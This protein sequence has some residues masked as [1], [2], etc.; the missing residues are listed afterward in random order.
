[1]PSINQFDGLQRAD[2]VI[3]LGTG[4]DNAN[5]S[6]GAIRGISFAVAGALKITTTGGETVTITSG[7]LAAG[8]IHPIGIVKVFA[9][10]T[11]CTGIWG[12]R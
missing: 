1:M 9:T 6:G 8:V 11:G 12:Y 4:D 10:G 7:A 5:V 3:S 2:T